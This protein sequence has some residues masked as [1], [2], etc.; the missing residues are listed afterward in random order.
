MCHSAFFREKPPLDQ[1]W[2]GLPGRYIKHWVFQRCIAGCELQRQRAV[3]AAETKWEG[4]GCNSTCTCRLEAV[5][6]G[7]QAHSCSQHWWHAPS[8]CTGIFVIMSIDIQSNVCAVRHCTGSLCRLEKPRLLL[9][10]DNIFSHLFP[11]A[12]CITQ[13]TFGQV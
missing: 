5:G 12:S 7:R 4:G 6:Y 8:C 1:E 13:T 3:S 2:T 9:Q 10:G 11:H